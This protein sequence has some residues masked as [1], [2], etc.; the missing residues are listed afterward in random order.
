M[1]SAAADASTDMDE[2]AEQLQ[3]ALAAEGAK[4]YRSF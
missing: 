3:Q 2:L 4:V 1:L